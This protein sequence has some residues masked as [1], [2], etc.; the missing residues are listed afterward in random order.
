[1]VRG[2]ELSED[3]K[4]SWIAKN[5]SLPV[6]KKPEEAAAED[7]YI[8]GLMA[9]AELDAG[10]DQ[11][12]ED[13]EVY[14]WLG[15]M[16]AEEIPD[17]ED[18]DAADALAAEVPDYLLAA[19]PPDLQDYAASIRA[20]ASVKETKDAQSAAEFK[21]TTPSTSSDASITDSNKQYQ[22]YNNHNNDYVIY[23]KINQM[24]HISA[25]RFWV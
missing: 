20:H 1:M 14:R 16:P 8:A 21:N 7:A 15:L 10:S 25:I 5:G 12:A 3:E 23:K 13:D 2:M 24:M 9:D 17:D 11:T 18:E 19:P 4:A 6:V 22:L